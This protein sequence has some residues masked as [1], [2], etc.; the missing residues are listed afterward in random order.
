MIGHSI[1]KTKDM[2]KYLVKDEDQKNKSATNYRNGDENDM[3]SASV[4][5]KEKIGPSGATEDT[6]KEVPKN[7]NQRINLKDKISLILILTGFKK[8]LGQGSM[9]F[10]KAT[11]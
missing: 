10:Y 1:P 11:P 9:I 8:T 7:H 5:D 3:D 6:K 2:K 4:K